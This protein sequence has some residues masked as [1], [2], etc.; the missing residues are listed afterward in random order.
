MTDE[1]RVER[2]EWAKGV[3]M[4]VWEGDDQ[5]AA[6]PESEAEKIAK[7]VGATVTIDP[8]DW[9]TGEVQDNGMLYVGRE[10]AGA[11][12]RWLIERED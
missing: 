8:D 1:T 4:E 11:A 2:T 7:A 10:H 12:V 5:L 3:F 9:G 6:I